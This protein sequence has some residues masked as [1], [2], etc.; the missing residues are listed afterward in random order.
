MT[1]DPSPK[2]LKRLR[3]SNESAVFL[4]SIHF[5]GKD[6]ALIKSTP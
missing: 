4:L 5:D 3:P 6:L 1:I 2:D